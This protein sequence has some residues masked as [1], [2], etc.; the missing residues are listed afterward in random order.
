MLQKGQVAA[1]SITNQTI[2]LKSVSFKDKHALK[3]ET[4]KEFGLKA[5]FGNKVWPDDVISG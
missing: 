1:S 4:D 3:E 5:T 2:D